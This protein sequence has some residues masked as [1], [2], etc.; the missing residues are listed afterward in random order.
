[1]NDEGTSSMPAT[2]LITDVRTDYNGQQDSE[3]QRRL[4]DWEVDEDD[5]L[6]SEYSGIESTG[7]K[8]GVLIVS[9]EEEEDS[10]DDKSTAT[11]LSL[12]FRTAAALSLPGTD[13]SVPTDP[14]SIHVGFER[15][16]SSI[17]S[18]NKFTEVPLI[19]K[20]LTDVVDG[21]AQTEH[22]TPNM[23]HGKVT[24][25]S[26]GVVVVMIVA[27]T[28]L[29]LD[30][31][32]WRALALRQQNELAI[33]KNDLI[34]M[35]EELAMA[36]N[37][38]HA[39]MDILSLTNWRD[40]SKED[41]NTNTNNNATQ[42]LEWEQT[43]VTSTVLLAD[44]CWFKA[45]ANFKL[46]D[47]ASNAKNGLDCVSST[48]Y[49]TLEGLGKVV[50]DTALFFKE[51]DT[52]LVFN[53]KPLQAGI[54]VDGLVEASN[55]FAS[56]TVAATDAMWSVV[57]YASQIVDDSILYAVEQTRDV[58]EDATYTMHYAMDQTI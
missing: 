11:D 9:G 52:N 44:N 34:V 30:R 5:D 4:E 22:H 23:D 24:F 26:I 14:G 15:V 50:W 39:A 57:S 6:V 7:T 29:S 37:A 41:L 13:C 19:R 47:C 55:A 31:N 1:M 18:T 35:K 40:Q 53:G 16:G 46:G 56:A 48:V 21:S 17:S 10:N 42:E 51:A 2:P 28:L 32:S 54:T 36:H 27:L 12:L 3:Q 58:L 49:Q 20:H 8:D 33:L 25:G 45:E 38:P 43:D